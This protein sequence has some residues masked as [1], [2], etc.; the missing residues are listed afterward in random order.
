MEQ[1]ICPNIGCQRSFLSLKGRNIH[2][3]RCKPVESA[4]KGKP[5]NVLCVNTN[6]SFGNVT[7]PIP[8]DPNIV[9]ETEENNS[10]SFNNNALIVPHYPSIKINT[11]QNLNKREFFEIIKPLLRRD[12]TFSS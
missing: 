9:L 3:S 11:T 4:I 10:N 6:Q 7:Q 8:T 12:S 1:Y 5:P 2:F